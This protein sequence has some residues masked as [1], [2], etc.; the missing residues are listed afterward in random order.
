MILSS[1]LLHLKSQ[2]DFSWADSMQKKVKAGYQGG[3]GKGKSNNF[4]SASCII[5]E[6]YV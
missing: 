1:Y 4:L 6:H 5:A 3:G 2:D